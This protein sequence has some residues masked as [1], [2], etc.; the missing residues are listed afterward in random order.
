MIGKRGM[1]FHIPL[2]PTK[3]MTSLYN[4]PYVWPLLYLFLKKTNLAFPAGFPMFFHVLCS[5]ALCFCRND[6]TNNL[7]NRD[8]TS[9]AMEC[10]VDKMNF[11]P[12]E[13]CQ[14]L[15]KHKKFLCQVGTV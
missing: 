9:G 11:L 13:V 5:I 12:N 10:L 1:N 8:E 14:L 3:I 4:I 15:Q 7:V 2:L 6:L